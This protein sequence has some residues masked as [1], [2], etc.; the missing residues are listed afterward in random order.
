MKKIFVI[1]LFLLIFL[2]KAY[3]EPV[4]DSYNGFYGLFEELTEITVNDFDEAV[5]KADANKITEQLFKEKPFKNDVILRKDLALYLSEK[6]SSDDVL[7][8]LNFQDAGLL[9]KT[10]RKP[11]SVLNANSKLFYDD[12][13]LNP[14]FPLTYGY[15]IESLAKFEDE[16]LKTLEITKEDG[17]VV[18]VSLEKDI[19]NIRIL[20]R[21]SA[22]DIKFKDIS[23]KNVYEYGYFAPYS[24]NIS[25]SDH[26]TTYADKNGNGLYIKFAD[27]FFERYK[28]LSNS[29]TLYKGLVY[30]IE[31]DFA[32]VKN[33]SEFDGY[34][35]S[36]HANPYLEFKTDANTVFTHNFNP[37]SYDYINENLLD[38][39]VFIICDKEGKAK[40]FNLSE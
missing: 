30:Y 20:T 37:T 34:R 33:V 17:D 18:S 2:P 24:R 22:K 21:F 19:T 40:Y 3:A 6:C 14:D 5:G 36:E 35:Y 10:L 9:D 32:V 1:A 13:F 16:I 11:Y 25:R 27:E 39:T 4:K 12:G 26:I 7:A 23:S 38:K 15:F 8:P 31:P 28:E 29:Y